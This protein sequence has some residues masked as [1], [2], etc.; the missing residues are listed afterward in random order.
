MTNNESADTKV[1]SPL[2]MVQSKDSRK[3]T[4]A[5]TPPTLSSPLKKPPVWQRETTTSTHEVSSPVKSS[6]TKQLPAP[7]SSAAG[8]PLFKKQSQS[9]AKSTEKESSPFSRQLPQQQSLTV[10]QRRA[11]YERNVVAGGGIP[12]ALPSGLLPKDSDGKKKLTRNEL[13]VENQK[14]VSV[15]AVAAKFDSATKSSTDFEDHTKPAAPTPPRPSAVSHLKQQRQHIAVTNVAA[16]AKQ[17]YWSPPRVKNV[18][19][20]RSH[21]HEIETDM[22]ADDEV[23]PMASSSPSVS[24]AKTP[25]IYADCK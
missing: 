13:A 16:T 25:G 2:K 3:V 24:L 11:L 4:F 22:T 7:V 15:A 8:N 10:A 18:L 12:G 17:Q 6:L 19:L 9:P 5:P 21:Q 20:K 14:P 23:V 1:Q